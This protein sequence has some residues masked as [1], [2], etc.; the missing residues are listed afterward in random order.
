MTS[1]NSADVPS[2][3]F[4]SA[5]TVPLHQGWRTIQSTI[6]APSRISSEDHSH[7]RAPNDAPDPRTS[8]STQA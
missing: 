1:S 7:T 6:S 3:E 4:P 5:A 2:Y 8:T